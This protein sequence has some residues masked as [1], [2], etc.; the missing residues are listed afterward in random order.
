MSQMH[1]FS[2]F[3]HFSKNSFISECRVVLVFRVRP[4]SLETDTS[5]G[6][7]EGRHISIDF[8]GESE[9]RSLGFDFID[10]ARL[11]TLFLGTPFPPCLPDPSLT[12]EPQSQSQFL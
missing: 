3:L 1:V 10:V 5:V 4:E 8:L 6:E 12:P 9:I 11:P 7:S 2:F